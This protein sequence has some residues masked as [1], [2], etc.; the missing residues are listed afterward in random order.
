MQSEMGEK[1]ERT[2]DRHGWCLTKLEWRSLKSIEL[3][4]QIVRAYKF[5]PYANIV[6]EAV[7]T[8][9]S[10]YTRVRSVEKK[11][12]RKKKEKNSQN[13]ENITKLKGPFH[14]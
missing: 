11:K 8:G 14:Q 6:A 3:Y 7:D 4:N 10:R 1:K 5:H 12:K 13:N 2:V 9:V